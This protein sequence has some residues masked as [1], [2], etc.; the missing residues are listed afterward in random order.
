MEDDE[1]KN[2]FEDG[3][4][5]GIENSVVNRQPSNDSRASNTD[6]KDDKKSTQD[7]RKFSTVWNRFTTYAKT[8]SSNTKEMDRKSS[9]DSL[10]SLTFLAK[11]SNIV[12]NDPKTSVVKSDPKKSVVK[13]NKND[14]SKFLATSTPK[15]TFS[16]SRN[17]SKTNLLENEIST[18]R[19]DSSDTVA[20]L[21]SIHLISGTDLVAMDNCGTSDPFVKFLIGE[22]LIHKSSTVM[23]QLNP[24]WDE[25][26]EHILE[27]QIDQQAAMTIEV[28][29]YDR[30]ASDDFMGSTSINLAHYCALS[31]SG[32]VESK[33]PLCDAE[34]EENYMGYLTMRLS[35]KALNKEER[36]KLAKIPSYDTTSLAPKSAGKKSGVVNNK[37]TS[38]FNLVVVEGRNLNFDPKYE[39]EYSVK[40]TLGLQK[41]KTKASAKSHNPKWNAP[42]SLRIYSDYRLTVRIIDRFLKAII[43]EFHIELD[44][45]TSNMTHQNWYSTNDCGGKLLLSITVNDSMI[46]SNSSEFTTPIKMEADEFTIRNTFRNLQNIGQLVVTVYKAE[47]LNSADFGGKSDP[48]CVLE[49]VNKRVQTHTV[50]KTLDPQWNKTFIFDVGDVNS[51]LEVT[52]YDEDANN[53][54]ELL[55]RVVI[56]LLEIKNGIQEWFTLRDKLLENE[57]KGRIMLEFDLA[58]NPIRAAIRTINPKEA[59]FIETDAKF[60]RQ[61]FLKQ[62]DRIK[63]VVN[64]ISDTADYVGSCLTWA[65]PKRSLFSFITFLVVI[66]IIELYMIPLFLVFTFLWQFSKHLLYGP[67]IPK[68][69]VIDN[70]PDNNNQNEPKKGILGKLA[71]A[72]DAMAQVQNGLKFTADLIDR[73]K[74]SANFSR[75]FLSS[76]AVLCFCVAA[77]ILYLV[78]L[79][80]LVL[81]WG[82]KKEKSCI[83]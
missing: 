47:G 45:L 44:K 10:D 3:W 14:S 41:F 38:T 83:D 37:W 63:S 33:L 19:G 32:F 67:Y 36:A 11:K 60:N 69:S 68:E 4:D 17:C 21:V 66:W 57:V 51:Y 15:S 49:L 20:H 55:G 72:Q 12:G 56:P 2:M 9:S 25:T 64:S 74:N 61:I 39:A 76:F 13:S 27:G 43:A 8:K 40:F 30:F 50:Y 78:P 58:W 81:L 73:F 28:Y 80:T 59:K 42:F 7:A 34:T 75:P 65:N 52:V 5:S 6:C 79:R 29:D 26:F 77:I 16:T 48:F 82:E 71:A 53:T 23:K 54:F 35:V 1:T 46:D 70:Q 62:V 22:K 31:S 24:Q 18:I